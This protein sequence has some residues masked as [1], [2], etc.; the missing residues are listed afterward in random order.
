[1]KTALNIFGLAL[2]VACGAVFFARAQ[3]AA[4]PVSA[5]TGVFTQAQ[6]DEGVKVYHAS[7]DEGCHLYRLEGYGRA[8]PLKGDTFK[9]DW[10]GKTLAEMFQFISA[11][12]PQD[13]PATLTPEEYVNVMAYV[14]SQNGFPA[15]AKPLTGDPTALAGIVFADE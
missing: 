3:D 8:K 14:L 11:K 7:C 12:M 13:F 15:G 4:P 2:V 10:H 1:M 6:A 9:Q 5:M